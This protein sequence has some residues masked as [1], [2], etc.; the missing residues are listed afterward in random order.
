[1]VDRGDE[2]LKGAVFRRRLGY[3]SE[4]GLEERLE[5][6]ARVVERAFCNSRLRVGVDDGEV[7]LLVGGAQLDEEIEDV[8]DDLHGARVPAVDLVD[9]D[10]GP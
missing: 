1:M 3:A 4:D 2:Q 7:G 10:D 8:V 5:I 9:H 6:V